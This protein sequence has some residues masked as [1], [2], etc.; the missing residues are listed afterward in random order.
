MDQSSET[1]SQEEGNGHRAC[2]TDDWTGSCIHENPV[3]HAPDG[4]P[5]LPPSHQHL[6]EEE[7]VFITINLVYHA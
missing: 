6:F 5:Q 3:R 2:L 4:Y 1:S 7:A